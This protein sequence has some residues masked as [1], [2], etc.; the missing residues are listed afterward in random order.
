M[1]AGIMEAGGSGVDAAVTTLLCLGVVHPHS[2]G[3]GGGSVWIVR[4]AEGE[5]HALDAREKAGAA[6]HKD[7]FRNISS[8]DGP[9]TVAVP[10]ELA[11]MRY[12][13]HRFGKLEWSKLLE[14]VIELCENGFVVDNSLYLAIVDKT[15][16]FPKDSPIEKT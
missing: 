6:A 11:G 14:P 2:S 3:L 8:E 7:M 13:H 10:G 1:G 16:R 9:L 4:E 15:K 5:Y 12:M